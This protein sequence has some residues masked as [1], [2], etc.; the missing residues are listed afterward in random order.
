LGGYALLALLGFAIV[1]LLWAVIIGTIVRADESQTVAS[2]AI[3]AEVS[4]HL[5]YTRMDEVKAIDIA[6]FRNDKYISVSL[7]SFRNHANGY[8]TGL[9]AE[10]LLWSYNL[11]HISRGPIR[12]VKW[13][14][15]WPI[16]F[17]NIW[18]GISD[19]H[20]TCGHVAGI[21]HEDS[22]AMHDHIFWRV[23][24]K[25]RISEIDKGAISEARGFIGAIQYLSLPISNHGEDYSYYNEQSSCDS[26][27]QSIELIKAVNNPIHTGFHGNPRISKEFAKTAFFIS[28]AVF[29]CGFVLALAALGH[30][31]PKGQ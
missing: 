1:L 28:C 18:A 26:C 31:S 2:K 23:R 6:D 21:V 14:F 11:R 16:R 29:V 27:N 10:G 17:E 24:H 22:D 7:L 19:N 9:Q 30:A 13:V 20:S 25:S 5:G 3:K 15:D 8:F 12:G 4:S